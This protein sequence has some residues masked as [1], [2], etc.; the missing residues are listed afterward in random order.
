MGKL[1][2]EKQNIV[3]DTYTEHA[4]HDTAYDDDCSICFNEKKEN[5]LFIKNL[6]NKRR[7]EML[8]NIGVTP[9]K[10]LV[11]HEQLRNPLE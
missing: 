6:M 2:E 7:K 9:E 8:E 4:L 3:V 11:E 5:D 1:I 10:A